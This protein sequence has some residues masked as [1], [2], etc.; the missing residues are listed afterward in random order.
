MFFIYQVSR[1]ILL[2]RHLMTVSSSLSDCSYMLLEQQL[3]A[4]F[5]EF[6]Q[7]AKSIVMQISFVMLIFLLFLNQI[8]G[9]GQKSLRGQTASGGRPLW[10]KARLL[11][12]GN[13]R[14]ENSQLST[15]KLRG[16]S[17]VIPGSQL[18]FRNALDTIHFAKK[19]YPGQVSVTPD[20]YHAVTPDI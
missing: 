20:S 2:P 1:S 17:G 6:F 3:L 4:F 12:F 8:S 9:G 16:L 19:N 14:V 7:E 15:D 5:Q 18:N 13:R 10:K 11:S